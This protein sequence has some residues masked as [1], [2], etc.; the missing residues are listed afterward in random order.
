MVTYILFLEIKKNV[1]IKVGSLGKIKFE[2]GIYAYVGSA[3]RNF[4]S[5]I[6]RHFSKNKKL[7][8][9]IDYLTTNKFVDPYSVY[10]VEKDEES[11]IARFLVKYWKPIPRFGSSDT[12]DLSHLFK[13]VNCVNE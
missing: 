8:W 7:H 9:H 12:N 10:I 1:S 13:I 6:S 5:R 11:K 3:K 4:K 2:K